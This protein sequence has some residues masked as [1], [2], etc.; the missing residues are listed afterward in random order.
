MPKNNIF[1]SLNK[2]RVKHTP[3][4]LMSMGLAGLLFS[5]VWAVKVTVK[6]TKLCEE[7]K[8]TEKKDNLT[9]KEI[10]KTTW[11]LYLPVAISTVL[12][13][14]CIIAGNRVSSKRSAALAAAYTLSEAALQEYQ[15]KTKEIIGEQKEQT[16]QEELVKD[17]AKLIESK[18][19]FI[20]ENDEQ[21]FL[22]TIT[23]RYFKSTWNRIQKA[24]NDLNEDALGSTCGCY[25]LDDWCE[26]LGL[27]STGAGTLLGWSVPSYGNSRGLMKIH[28][29]TAKTKDDKACG[30]ICYDVRPYDY[31]N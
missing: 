12:S 16:I 20:S 22:E 9:F 2:F 13:V 24:C 21:L 14:P 10:F 3:E 8:I 31:N 29:T 6:A 15:I 26:K 4:I 7:K 17:K 28:M 27:D 11:K 19:V 30:A 1:N 25:N 18:E 5:T 23:G